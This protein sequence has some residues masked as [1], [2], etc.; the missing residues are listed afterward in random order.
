MKLDD[1]LQNTQLFGQ[2]WISLEKIFEDAIQERMKRKV[3]IDV[4]LDGIQVGLS[5]GDSS[6]MEQFVTSRFEQSLTLKGHQM[7]VI[8]GTILFN[9]I[10]DVR[11]LRCGV[12]SENGISSS[13]SVIVGTSN[14]NLGGRNK[15][16]RKLKVVIPIEAQRVLEKT[17]D[18]VELMSV[19]QKD[20]K[21]AK[22]RKATKILEVLQVSHKASMLSWFT[23]P[24]RL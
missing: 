23:D 7:G 6:V 5:A 14:L 22:V 13:S 3:D 21:D 20:D 9:R 1:E 17:Q 11:Q 8:F 10:P 16:A 4:Q 18:L 2:T 24:R 15:A 12:I 19:R